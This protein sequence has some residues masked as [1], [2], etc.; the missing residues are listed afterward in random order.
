MVVG[1]TRLGVRF[2]RRRLDRGLIAK[3]W[4][5]RTAPGSRTVAG[6][7]E[8]ALTMAVDAA[9]ACLGDADPAGF[10]G[11]Y[12]ASTSAP[13][14]EKQVASVVATAIDL[15]RTAAVADFGGST[16]AG[17]A[18]LRAAVRRGARRQPASRAGRG[19][20]RARRRARDRARGAARRRRRL[21]RR[22]DGGRDRRAR[23]ARRRS[24]RSSPTSG[25]PTSS[26]TS[27]SPTRASATSTGTR[28]TSPTR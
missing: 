28:A 22:R 16:R 21:R 11:L 18:A 4:G 3:A 9:L 25:G 2:P 15:P 26:A 1:I 7:D 14:L 8:D 19:R 5:S 27:R 20:R 10:D 6:V 13:Y 17:L 23:R 12:F 24:R